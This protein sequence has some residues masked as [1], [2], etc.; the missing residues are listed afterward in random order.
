MYFWRRF[1]C[2]SREGVKCISWSVL[3]FTDQFHLSPETWPLASCVPKNDD[4]DDI[5]GDGDDGIC[6]GG[7]DVICGDGDDGIGDDDE[8]RQEAPPETWSLAP[9]SYMSLIGSSN[10]QTPA[11][12]PIMCFF[13]LL[14]LNI[15]IEYDKIYFDEYTSFQTLQILTYF[16]IQCNAY[17]YTCHDYIVV[18]VFF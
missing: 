15:F 18:S 3:Q 12:L 6:G 7:D 4:D 16:Y 17:I 2:I 5:G 10:I 1:L 14:A 9:D 11:S 13:S 8:F